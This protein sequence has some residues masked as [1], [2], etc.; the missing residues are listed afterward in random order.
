MSTLF[1]QK[2]V[3]TAIGLN[4]SEY[5]LNSVE[6]A[7]KQKGRRFIKTHLPYSLLP[8]QIKNGTKSPKVSFPLSPNNL[9]FAN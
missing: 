1:D 4:E 9:Y 7:R 6:F 8:D 5:N 2:K 3:Y